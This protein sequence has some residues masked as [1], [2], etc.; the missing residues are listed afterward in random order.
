M[1][2]LVVTVVIIQS[3]NFRSPGPFVVHKNDTPHFTGEILATFE[4]VEVEHPKTAEG[5]AKELFDQY[6]L[7]HPEALH[8]WRFPKTQVIR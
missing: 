8:K 4:N 1:P 7:E 6:I 3:N 2:N 5:V